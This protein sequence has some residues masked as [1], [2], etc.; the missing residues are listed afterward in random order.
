MLIKQNA[1][2]SKR[3]LEDTAPGFGSTKPF[4]RRHSSVSGNPAML[5]PEGR[6]APVMHAVSS[7]E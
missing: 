6:D 3:T 4:A 5:A 1:F 7:P 2:L